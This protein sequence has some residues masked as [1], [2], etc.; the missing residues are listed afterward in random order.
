MEITESVVKGIS[1][2]YTVEE[3]QTEL[4]KAVKEMLENPERVV[5]AST[6]SGASYT[7]DLMISPQELVELLTYALE[8]KRTGVISNGGSNIMDTI[9]FFPF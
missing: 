8:Y 7:K 6:G 2:L 1:A 3:L 5:S 4:Q 9:T